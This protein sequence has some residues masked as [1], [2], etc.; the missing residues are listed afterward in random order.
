MD[1]Q[2][3]QQSTKADAAV[4]DS[5]IGRMLLD[6]GK[7]TSEGAE[8]V[9]KIQKEKGL[10][11]GE[12]AQLL[13][14][15]TEGDIQQVLARQFDYAYLQ[16]GEGGFSP[17]LVAAY[18]PFSAEVEAYR[19]LRSQLVIRHFNTGRKVLAIMSVDGAADSA[20][21]AA[22]LAVVFSQL[23]ERTA[24]VDANL[25]RPSQ[26]Q[27][28]NLAGRMGLSDVLAGRAGPEALVRI[29]E[30]MALS[31]LHAGTVPPNPQELLNRG[32]FGEITEE[33]A[34]E[35]DVILYDVPSMETGADAFNV[36][37]RCGA[38]LLVARKN[39]TRV[40]NVRSA[41]QQLERSGVQVVGNVM[42][43]E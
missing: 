4:R 18:Q 23:G 29:K 39:S 12:A 7:I 14:L 43:E 1:M 37:A 22:N 41:V 13:G 5:S 6:L 10:R 36:A 21:I 19:A 35:H 34:T 17:K 16:P 38:V 11:F 2:V 3:A 20:I 15:V 33:L 31:V 28:F 40:A 27:I 26:H 8:R 42:L 32:V 30:F 9:L 24:L 25:R